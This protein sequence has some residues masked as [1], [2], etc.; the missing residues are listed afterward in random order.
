[1]LIQT[2]T[3]TWYVLVC[4]MKYTWPVYSSC[5]NCRGTTLSYA[6]LESSELVQDTATVLRHLCLL[7]QQP[8]DCQQPA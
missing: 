6:G 7:E 1:M 5:Y 2:L 3:G 8:R 4:K